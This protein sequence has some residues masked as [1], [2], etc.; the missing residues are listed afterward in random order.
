MKEL[1]M[2]AHASTPRRPLW[3][4]RLPF[5]YGWIVVTVAFVTMGIGVNA[6]TSFSLLYPPILAEF[7]WDRGETAAAFSIGFLVSSLYAPF[8]GWLMDRLGPRLVIPLGVVLVS[9]GMLLATPLTA[10]MKIVFERM[11]PTKPMAELLAGRL[12]ALRV[13]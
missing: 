4:H 2:S 6:R 11:E 8:I 3:V 5:F 9:A 7:G 12:D 13:D 1:P 10:V